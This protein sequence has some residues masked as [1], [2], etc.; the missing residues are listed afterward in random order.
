[1]RLKPILW[2]WSL[3]GLAAI[4]T[5]LSLLSL[6]ASWHW[7][8]GLLEHP[9]PQYCLALL[10]VLLW[11][12]LTQR[13]WRWLW[14]LPLILNLLLIGPGYWLPIALPVTPSANSL[15]LVH[16][17]LARDNPTPEKAIAFLEQTQADWVW[18]QEVTP[19]WLELIH[20]ELPSYEV[21]IAEPRANS[22]GVALLQTYA[23]RQFLPSVQTEI[24]HF[25][26]G[27]SR[28][29][30]IARLHWQQNPITFLG[31]H[32][33]RPRNLQTAAFQQAEFSAVADWLAQQPNAIALGDFN[34]TPWSLN[35]RRLLKTTGL[36]DSLVGWGWQNT[37]PAS[38]PNSLSIPIDHCIHAPTLSVQ[39][40]RLGPAIGSDHLPLVVT[41]AL[42]PNQ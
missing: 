2:Q 25:P 41:L 5:L 13:W 22:H 36:V 21:L 27:S 23:P 24:R 12:T 37:W 8:L 28:P 32:T 7:L 11:A 31:L 29:M 39:E 9:R 38:V 10:P 20:H 19:E 3:E 6:L 15:T 33:T 26:E 34:A 18:L 17:N 35:F 42:P 40:R 4:A 16:L 14:G 1:M 30:I